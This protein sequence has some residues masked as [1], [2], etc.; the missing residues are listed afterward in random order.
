[1]TAPATGR[2]AKSPAFPRH[3]CALLRLGLFEISTYVL[4]KQEDNK[5]NIYLA[6]GLP[7]NLPDIYL[8]ST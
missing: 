8:T 7:L 6:F 5:K 1:M 3:K 2:R 4:Q